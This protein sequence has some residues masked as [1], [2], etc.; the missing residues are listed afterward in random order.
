M[1]L[2]KNDRDFP[3]E[4][5]YTEEGAEKKVTIEAG[6][7]VEIPEDQVEG[8]TKQ[9]ADAVKPTEG[10]EGEGEGED[11]LSDEEKALA[12]RERVVA[13]KE[14]KLLADQ[15]EAEFDKL[16]S[17][18]KVVPA[19]KEAFLA[20]SSQTSATVELAE[21]ES[22]TVAVLLS[23]LLEKAPKIKLDDEEGHEG[24]EGEGDEDVT[25]LSEE[26][27]SFAEKF[28]NTPEELAKFKKENGGK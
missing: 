19:Q 14:A 15:S 27:K 12:E 9:I 8:V 1:T 16:L 22:K 10:G 26:E 5:T 21:G 13:E 2:V 25:E 23:E 18:G 20:L 3:V 4:V 17:E 11:E 6:A 24:E 28:G 7:E